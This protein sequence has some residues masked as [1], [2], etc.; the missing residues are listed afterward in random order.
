MGGLAAFLILGFEQLFR[1]CEAFIRKGYGSRFA[2]R[3]GD[4]ALF[5]Q[6]IE[7]LPIVAF[8]RPPWAILLFAE[9]G[10]K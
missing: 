4:E 9:C 1:L 6:T 2:F 5:A 8:P 3:I 7:N 10:Q